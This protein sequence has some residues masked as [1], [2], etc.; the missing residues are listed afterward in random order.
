MLKCNYCGRT[1]VIGAYELQ[2]RETLKGILTDV[3]KPALDVKSIQLTESAFHFITFLVCQSR[4]LMV[5]TAH[6]FQDV[7]NSLY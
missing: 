3:Q 2:R 5:L 1:C 6:H 7:F 4:N